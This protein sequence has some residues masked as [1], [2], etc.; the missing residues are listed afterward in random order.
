MR[1]LLVCCVVCL[2]AAAAA[3]DSDPVPALT[4]YVTRVNS[5]ADFDVSGWHIVCGP[6]TKT[7]MLPQ[8]PSRRH[9]YDSGCPQEPP[10]IGLPAA[11]WGTLDRK[12][13]AIQ[14]TQLDLGPVPLGNIFSYGI[15]EAILSQSPQSLI[16]R[17]DG[18]TIRVD[19]PI[20]PE[21]KAPL[22]SLADV[23][24][25]VWLDYKGEQE[26]DGTV[27]AGEAR[28]KPNWPNPKAEKTRART[29]YNPFQVTKPGNGAAEVLI[30][31]NAMKIPTWPDAA[32]QAR[33]AAIGKKLVPAY[34]RH[35]PVGDGTKIDF[36]FYV[37][38]GDRWRRGVL[39]LPSGI[40]L[41]PHQIVDRMQNDSQLAAILADS[42]AVEMEAQDTRMLQ[43]IR[44]TPRQA[45]KEIA[46]DASEIVAIGGVET[47]AAN[48][49]VEHH[50]FKK[51]FQQSGRVSLSLMHEAG[52]DVAE[53]PIAW[54]RL[55]VKD[56]DSLLDTPLPE[57]SVNLYRD[58]STTWQISPP[59]PSQ[60]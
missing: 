11:V 49:I 26:A 14:A 4:G 6:E 56:G 23:T 39:P 58:L 3:Q 45:T 37:T 31:V 15:I 48:M 50:R 17:A 34:Q 5:A 36:R 12:Q 44:P 19:S 60:P 30:G 35:L 42:I 29:D 25:N 16:V 1:A 46:I 13:Q 21:F 54:W 2:T 7:T 22:H 24:T 27:L 33:V 8:H 55:S 43:G 59:S 10:R 28:F 32:M 57:Q 9:G 53:A 18:L 47:L 52:F 38:A 40:I 20:H 51:E 41:V